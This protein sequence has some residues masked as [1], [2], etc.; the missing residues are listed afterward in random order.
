MIRRLFWDIETSPNIHYAWGAG[1]K[2]FL[3]PDSIIK[4]R[5]IICIC[6]KW[7]GESKVHDLVWEPWDDRELVKQFAPIA[8]E[9]DELVAHNGDKF[10]IRWF[11]GR[12]LI[13]GLDPLPQYKTIDTY[14]IAAKHFKLNSYKLDYLAQVLFGDKKIKTDFDLWKDVCLHHDGAQK[15]LD[16]MVR[17]CRKDVKLLER[18]YN[19]LAA[20]D[21][22]KT[23]AGVFGGGERWTCPHCGSD[24]VA[25]SK[26]RVTPKGMKQRQMQCKSCRRYYTIANNVYHGY[27]DRN[28]E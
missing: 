2:V 15:A 9:A 1:R 3:G 27:R 8:N 7:A 26:T 4:E 25:L 14:K 16:K 12:N 24:D 20:Y 23:H 22:P 5:N 21:T 10:D 11:N 19:E 17:Y 6:Y 28:E 18:V 13:H